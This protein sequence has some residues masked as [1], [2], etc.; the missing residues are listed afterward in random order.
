MLSSLSL[1]FLLV[2]PPTVSIATNTGVRFLR[3]ANVAFVI[4]D[5]VRLAKLK[6]KMR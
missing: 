6:S 3:K 1:F 2:F 5:T 4:H